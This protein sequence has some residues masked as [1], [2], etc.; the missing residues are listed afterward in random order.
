[1][2]SIEVAP[3]LV[4][5]GAMFDVAAAGVAAYLPELATLTYERRLTEPARWWRVP[6]KDGNCYKAECVLLSSR[7][8]TARLT[9]WFLRDDRDGTQPRPHSHPWPFVSRILCGGYSEDRYE[10]TGAVAETGQAPVRSQLG[11]EHRAGGVNDVPLT[12]CR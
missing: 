12:G 3:G 4:L 8:K 2:S 6:D 10:L 5:D 7:E 11:V 1:M 9:C